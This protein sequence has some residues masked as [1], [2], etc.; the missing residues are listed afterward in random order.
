MR[1]A[2]PKALVLAFGFG[3]PVMATDSLSDCRHW[4]AGAETPV[5]VEIKISH[6]IEL[7]TNFEHE[8]S[9]YEKEAGG[10]VQGFM[11][12][13]P[14]VQD[15]PKY[16]APSVFV[17]VV[18]VKSDYVAF[19]LPFGARARL[20][21]FDGREKPF[22]TG[23]LSDPTPRTD[24]LVR[25]LEK[26]ISCLRLPSEKTLVDAAEALEDGVEIAALVTPADPLAVFYSASPEADLGGDETV[27]DLSDMFGK[28]VA[29][30]LRK[31]APDDGSLADLAAARKGDTP[32]DEIG[33]LA[34]LGGSAPPIEVEPVVATVKK[35]I[36]EPRAEDLSTGSVCMLASGREL[37]LAGLDMTPAI[38]VAGLAVGG[39][40]LNSFTYE[41]LIDAVLKNE[42]E[43]AQITDKGDVL[44]RVSIDGLRGHLVED[45]GKM[46]VVPV[47]LPGTKI[48]RINRDVPEAVASED[49]LNVYIVGDA[50]S[51]RVTGLTRLEAAA[52]AKLGQVYWNIIWHDV[53]K[54]GAID[55]GKIYGSMA[56]LDRDLPKT[57]EPVFL[58]SAAQ[59]E[60]FV[61]DL[62]E[63]AVNAPL[64]IDQ[65]YW[66][67]EGY[68]LPHEA[69]LRVSKALRLINA[70]GNI[71][72]RENG[73]P[74]KWLQVIAGTYAQE[75]SRYYLEGPVKTAVPEVGSMSVERRDGERKYILSDLTY[76]QSMLQYL[77][78]RRGLVGDLPEPTPSLAEN[79][80]RF[81]M[82]R[83]LRSVGYLIPADMLDRMSASVATTRF[84]V[85]QIEQGTAPEI[86]PIEPED[87]DVS[88]LFWPKT[89]VEG[90]LLGLDIN[91]R[92]IDRRLKTLAR[93]KPE[94]DVKRAIDALGYQIALS[95][96]VVRSTGCEFVF[97]SMKDL[98]L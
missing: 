26:P 23:R 80:L 49:R 87:F 7:G 54:N 85:D 69:P 74:L 18:D 60:R 42:G 70:K 10:Q 35:S 41:P 93:A 67:K 29:E 73:N 25:E 31:E 30:D 66:I 68:L 4:S 39:I 21:P 72:R 15:A 89:D 46:P 63:L 90:A 91:A 16:I 45:A 71:A 75:F 12:L 53:A 32:D 92:V 19:S 28:P 58:S 6:V 84:V 55:E 17:A 11:E 27:G 5:N 82:D 97:V 22:R 47:G 59:F 95:R 2:F 36:A 44:T 76:P 61:G 3:A 81:N 62:E 1:R 20:L 8:G 57:R 48:L 13:E 43:S 56:E 98:T 37:S 9:T 33:G 50:A 96:G 83:A 88:A 38:H 52:K 14:F 34:T 77:A 79:E 64:R 78:K 65:L 94:F 51:V 86:I 24:K 40:K